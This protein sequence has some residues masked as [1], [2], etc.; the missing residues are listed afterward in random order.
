MITLF[1]LK[2]KGFC[3]IF[4]RTPFYIKNFVLLC[5]LAFVL[6][7]IYLVYFRKDGMVIQN[8]TKI[9]KGLNSE[10]FNYLESHS[11]SLRL[12]KLLNNYQAQIS[13]NQ[14]MDDCVRINKPCKF[15]GL[16]QKW[17]ASEKW[18]FNSDTGYKYLIDTIGDYK[19]NVYK[20]VQDD[21]DVFKS[22]TDGNSF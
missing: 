15:E 9:L 1:E 17:P 3:K 14:F 11:D 5:Q 19:L 4:I 8:I 7:C 12:T 6:A 21:Y 20:L 18:Q 2:N 13:S 16:A 10:T 22:T